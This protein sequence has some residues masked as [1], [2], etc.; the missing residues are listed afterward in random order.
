MAAR[1]D[2]IVD[3]Q[4]DGLERLLSGYAPLAGIFDEMMDADGQVRP[5]WRP[6]LTMLASLGA[7][8]INPLFAVAERYLHDS[9]LFYRIYEVPA[10]SEP[11]YLSSHYPRIF[12]PT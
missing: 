7:D 10:G 6:F 9:G 5:H 8:E 3:A 4:P 11:P 2:T 12:N 1:S